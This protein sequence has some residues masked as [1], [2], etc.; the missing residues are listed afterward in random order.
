MPARRV[1][2]TCSRAP[3]GARRAALLEA[4]QVAL[5][6]AAQAASFAPPT[7]APNPTQSS[8]HPA[9]PA[10]GPP[11]PQS[12][13]SGGSRGNAAQSGVRE[14]GGGAPGRALRAAPSPRAP[15]PGQEGDR[16]VA[17]LR[18]GK[19]AGVARTAGAWCATPTGPPSRPPVQ[20]AARLG[21]GV[22]CSLAP[23]HGPLPAG[24]HRVSQRSRWASPFA[25][26]CRLPRCQSAAPTKSRNGPRLAIA[27]SGENT[28]PGRVPAPRPIR[29]SHP[30]SEAA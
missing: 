7:S 23:R 22:I 11:A 3:A 20:E 13:L 18:A 15:E 17:A 26:R 21:H 30:G 1:L 12:R 27:F 6:P 19:A 24:V 2:F 10:L 8:R 28:H 4:A 9:R 29:R 14:A 16:R 5:I 25:I